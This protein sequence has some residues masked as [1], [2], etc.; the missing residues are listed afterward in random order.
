MIENNVEAIVEGNRV[1]YKRYFG[2]PIDLLFEVWSSQEHLSEW[3]GPD[4]FTL[5]TTRL[6]FSS[7]GVW[8]FIMHGPMDT[9]IKTRSDL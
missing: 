9:T 2:I 6:D 3:W 5:T 8:E 7:G 1:I 4:G